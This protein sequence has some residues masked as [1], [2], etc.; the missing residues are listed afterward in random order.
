[1]VVH[2]FMTNVWAGCV[3]VYFWIGIRLNY[4]IASLHD[5]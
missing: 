4:I 2:S 5:S 3:I 1:M